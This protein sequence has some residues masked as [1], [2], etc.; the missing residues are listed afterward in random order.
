MIRKSRFI[1]R[2]RDKV[3]QTDDLVIDK[4]DLTVGR[5]LTHDLILNH[6]A[7]SRTHAGIKEVEGVFWIFNL[8]RSNGTLLN[9]EIVDKSPLADNDEIQIGPY[10]L[11]VGYSLEGLLLTVSLEIGNAPPQ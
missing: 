1:I 2:R 9:G 11:R 6:G 8:S 7:V 10:L 4:E 5:L 3:I